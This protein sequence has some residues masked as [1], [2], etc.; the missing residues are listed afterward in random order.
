MLCRKKTSDK[1]VKLGGSYRASGHSKGG[2]RGNGK[3]PIAAKKKG[4]LGHEG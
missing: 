1:T 2:Y 3:T 4:E